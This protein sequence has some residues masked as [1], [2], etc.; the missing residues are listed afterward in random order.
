MSGKQKTRKH[1][2]P[3]LSYWYI[4]PPWCKNHDIYW[5][6]PHSQHTSNY[7]GCPATSWGTRTTAEEAQE[8]ETPPSRSSSTWEEWSDDIL[9]T[10]LIVRRPRNTIQRKPQQQA[11]SPTILGN[12]A[13]FSAHTGKSAAALRLRRWPALQA[14]QRLCG[15]FCR[16]AQRRWTE[17]DS[18]NIVS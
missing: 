3:D 4:A 17:G 10:I 7:C 13:V 5:R 12:V 16:Y 14:I 11:A 2:L 1:T 18:K 8:D 9:T 15:G 6:F